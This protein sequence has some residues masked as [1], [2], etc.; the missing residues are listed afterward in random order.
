MGSTGMGVGGAVAQPRRLMRLHD[1]GSGQLRFSL[2]KEGSA[3]SKNDLDSSDVFVLDD[4]GKQ[5]WVWEGLGSSKAERAMWLK[6][7]Q[8]YLRHVQDKGNVSE[9]LHL[10]PIAK[11]LE[12]R[13]S[14]AFSR[15][16][17]AH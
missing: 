16:I 6:A 2:V 5:I 8:S 9:S 17:A 7:A 10:T 13:E 12:G 14:P 4:G 1:D 11:V 15:A 3:V